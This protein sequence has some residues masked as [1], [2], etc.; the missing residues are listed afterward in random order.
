MQEFQWLAM[1]N[2]A[3]TKGVCVEG[4]GKE[5]KWSEIGSVR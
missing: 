4:Y 3:S 2:G 5:N 1:S